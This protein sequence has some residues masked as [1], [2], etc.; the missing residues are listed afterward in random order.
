MTNPF[1]HKEGKRLHRKGSRYILLI[2]AASLL[3]ACSGKTVAYHNYHSLPAYGWPIH[4][5]LL[6]DV[7]IDDSATT[8]RLSIEI[9]H[10]QKYPFQNLDIAVSCLTPDSILLPTDSLH[11]TLTDSLGNWQG[12]GLGALYQLSTPAQSI[13]ISRSGTYRFSITH[14]SDTDTLPGLNDVGIKLWK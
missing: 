7:H 6:F 4:D 5:S 10:R 11:L 9:R 13:P 14:T 1:R 8:Y 12:K 3:C 2:L